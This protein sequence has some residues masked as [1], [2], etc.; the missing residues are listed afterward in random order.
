[1]S[2]ALLLLGVV[3]LSPQADPAEETLRITSPRAG[4]PLFGRVEVVVES[5]RDDLTSVEIFVDGRSVAVLEEGPYRVMVD[6]G[7]NNEPH[8]VD[9]RASHPGGEQ[10]VGLISSVFAVDQEVT[11]ELRQLYVTVLEE[12]RR[13][14]GLDVAEFS[15]FDEGERQDIVTF[16]RGDLRVQASILVDSST[17]MRGGRLG[18]ALRGAREFMAGLGSEDEATVMLFS[19]RLLRRTPFSSDPEA[20]L[21]SLAGVEAGGGTALSDHLYFALKLAEPR[22]GRR[23]LLLL[24]DGVDS[25]SSL[26]IRDVEWIARRSRSMIYWVRT[27][28]VDARKSHYSAWKGPDDYR[29]ETGQLERLVSES[30]GRVVP[31]ENIEDAKAVLREIVEELRSQFVLGY[32]PSAVRKDGSWHKVNVRVRSPELRVRARDGYLDF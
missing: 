27:G 19:D 5:D 20:V 9:A 7:Q 4:V 18:F 15:I 25:H 6:V 8:R 16:G 11:A 21:S 26:S 23:V 2:A 31:L 24:S 30:G 32:Y 28:L 22:L 29:R 10:T 13:V 14:I 3:L 17:S 1:M 12:G